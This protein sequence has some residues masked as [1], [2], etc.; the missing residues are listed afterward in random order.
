MPLSRVRSMRMLAR[1]SQTITHA[2]RAYGNIAVEEFA[3]GSTTDPDIPSEHIFATWYGKA[4]CEPGDDDDQ[5]RKDILRLA[6]IYQ[7]ARR[8]ASGLNLEPAPFSSGDAASIHNWLFDY[9]AR[10]PLDMQNR[11]WF[12]LTVCSSR[13]LLFERWYS[14]S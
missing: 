7:E 3:S 9:W 11:A 6:S 12:D 14:P 2:A 10:P 8:G 1:L 13:Q 4:D 5:L